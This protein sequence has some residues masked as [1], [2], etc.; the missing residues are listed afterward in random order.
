MEA[1]VP[2]AQP[3]D[4]ALRELRARLRTH[5][6]RE[7]SARGLLAEGFCDQL[8]IGLTTNRVDCLVQGV[9]ACVVRTAKR[10]RQRRGGARFRERRERGLGASVGRLGGKVHLVPVSDQRNDSVSHPSR[11]IPALKSRD[12]GSRS[13]LIK[14]RLPGRVARRSHSDRA[15][16]MAI[17][18]S[19]RVSQLRS[20]QA[21]QLGV[22]HTAP[23]LRRDST[24]PG[25]P[26]S[27]KESPST[28]G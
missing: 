1:G 8:P 16:L 11:T 18:A 12:R 21:K 15:P 20:A 3:R 24:A 28:P 13:S 7:R 14:P 27:W 26:F 5:G 10:R 2:A 19:K 17:S 25:A 4:V 6:P 22:P 23:K 9:R